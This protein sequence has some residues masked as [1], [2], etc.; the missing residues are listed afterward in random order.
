VPSEILNPR[1]TWADK[2][3]YDETA[4]SLALK[5]VKNFEKYA[6]E[7]SDEIKAAAPKVMV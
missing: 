4:N 7:T 3:A 2:S 5:F 1:S 6:A